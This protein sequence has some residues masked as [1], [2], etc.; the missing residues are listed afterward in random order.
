M[1]QTWSQTFPPKPKFKADDVPDLTG[2]VML[3]TGK[4]W[5]FVLDMFMVT[6]TS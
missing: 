4:I 5:A 2:K 3:V 1:G 6:H